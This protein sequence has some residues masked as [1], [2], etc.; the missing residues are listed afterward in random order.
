MW[1][2]TTEAG[3]WANTDC[4][5]VVKIRGELRDNNRMPNTLTRVTCKDIW[6]QDIWGWGIDT[7]KSDLAQSDLKNG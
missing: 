5:S 3:I 1:T 6:G 4:F 7:M 2:S